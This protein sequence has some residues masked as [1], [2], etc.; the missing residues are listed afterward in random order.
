MKKFMFLLCIVALGLIFITR[1]SGQLAYETESI[2]KNKKATDKWIGIVTHFVDSSIHILAP[3]TNTLYG[4]FLS[5]QLGEGNSSIKAAIIPDGKT[6][7]IIN[8]NSYSIFFVELSSRFNIP[9]T[10]QDFINIGYN[11]ENI[12]ITPDGKQ[13]LISY[14]PT[15]NFIAVVDVENHSLISTFDLDPSHMVSEMKI[16]ADGQTV[17]IVDKSNKKIHVLLLDIDG[18]LSLKNSIGLSITPGNISISPD[19]L[20]AIVVNSTDGA[21]GILRID[22]PGNV[23]L[24]EDNIIVPNG[25]G[26]AAAFSTSEDK[27]YYISQNDS[28]IYLYKLKIETPNT[29][30]ISKTSFTE[31][32]KKEDEMVW[33]ENNI[34]ALGFSDRFAYIATTTSNNNSRITVIDLNTSLQVKTLT[35][36]NDFPT[37]ITFGR[38]SSTP[39]KPSS[40][41]PPFGSFDTPVDGSTVR[42]S[43]AVTGWALDDRGIESLK[44]YREDGKNLAYIGDALFIE[45][46]RPDIAQTYPDYPDNTKAGWGYMMLTNFLPNGDGIYKLHVIA[47]DTSGQQTTLGI[48]TTTVDNAT[49]VKPFG[50]IDNPQP[51]EVVIGT[52]Y[53]IQGWVLTPQPNKIPEDGSTI[54]VYIDGSYIGNCT[55][56]IYRSDI[57]N[58]FPEYAN[59]N[60]ALA[61]FDFNSTDYTNGL[62][63]LHWMVTD[64]A[65]NTDGI[66][67]RYFTIGNESIEELYLMA[68]LPSLS[69]STPFNKGKAQSQ[70]SIVK[71]II[72]VTGN[73]FRT[74][75][76]TEKIINID[77]S[78]EIGSP[79]GVVFVDGNDNLLGVLNIETSE[80]PLNVLPL[81]KLID[82]EID[83]GKITFGV[84]SEGN[85]IATPENDPIGEGKV[86]DMTETEKNAAA[87]TNSVLSSII[88]HPD[89]NNNGIIDYLEDKYYRFCFQYHFNAG[90]V[91][92]Y[93]PGDGNFDTIVFST[94]ILNG[95]YTR[96]G[97]ISSQNIN[98]NWWNSRYPL[99]FPDSWNSNWQRGHYTGSI[100]DDDYTQNNNGPGGGTHYPTEGFYTV[101]ITDDGDSPYDVQFY[102]SGQNKVVDSV[103]IAIPTYHVNGGM[104]Q[105]ITWSWKLR[106]NIQGT[107]IDPVAFIDDFDIAI[108]DLSS[109][110]NNHYIIERIY[111]SSGG[112]KYDWEGVWLTGAEE[113]HILGRSDV[114]WIECDRI[115]FGYSDKFGNV[116]I[117]Q[118]ERELPCD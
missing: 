110:G 82:S 87:L 49:T 13:A 97:V 104:L 94:A 89:A 39:D 114:P 8:P 31:I 54:K 28:G 6:A 83:L 73:S 20:L 101:T 11:A 48:K 29:V 111:N 99:D 21:P 14:G 45:G 58:L 71:K 78:S 95:F 18:N 44:I 53:R 67:S 25:C 84:D 52:S 2:S 17:L 112:D 75:E 106:N 12:T 57:A 109:E 115:D 5:G 62:H 50:A 103:I 92:E 117:V 40:D 22:S 72:L 19:G 34:T 1:T 63:T 47:T 41:Q 42:S 23:T 77:I 68:E 116:V 4:P 105:K 118:F 3:E 59:S 9:P 102:I 69:E 90:R 51:G 85:K 35:I 56:N 107:T 108:N 36:K 91:P 74:V 80:G 88:K 24:I 43:I 46:A 98:S 37:G 70:P 65:G 64:N 30:S 32:V 10:I 113:E 27:A 76:E 61:Y 100:N 86:I 96:C 26:I 93:Q 81:T 55:Y 79:L 38:I 15:E 66:G 16:A 7:I 60:G 33:K